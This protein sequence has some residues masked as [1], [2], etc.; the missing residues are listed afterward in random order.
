MK[1]WIEF[2]FIVFD[3]MNSNSNSRLGNFNNNYSTERQGENFARRYIAN[4]TIKTRSEL[5][6]LMRHMYR[7][8]GNS[9]WFHGGL[10][11]ITN[12]INHINKM[13]NKW[14]TGVR[15][16]RAA[17]NFRKVMKRETGR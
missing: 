14:R 8:G 2:F 15:K 6:W 5:G 7:F 10:K 12:R 16:I 13:R 1:I 4:G 3:N 9:P 11:V 17:K